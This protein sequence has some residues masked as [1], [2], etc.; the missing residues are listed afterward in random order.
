MPELLPVLQ[1]SLEWALPGFSLLPFERHLS[2]PHQ[3]ALDPPRI[4]DSI[5]NHS[6]SQAEW[7]VGWLVL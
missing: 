4:I 2:R 7:Q 6:V 3:A 1:E 5:M